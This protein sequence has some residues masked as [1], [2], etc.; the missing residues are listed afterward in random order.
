MEIVLVWPLSRGWRWRSVLQQIH[1]C[2]TRHT[3][4]VVQVIRG[5]NNDCSAV[6]CGDSNQQ[7]R[8]WCVNTCSP[9]R[10][11]R[12]C[13]PCFN[14]SNSFIH[15][16][17]TPASA[18]AVNPFADSKRESTQRAPHDLI[19]QTIRLPSFFQTDHKESLSSA[20]EQWCKRQIHKLTPP[21]CLVVGVLCVWVRE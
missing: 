7:L 8:S 17:S 6:H 1:A 3:T 16:S 9:L 13:V 18:R 4:L 20:P 14:T 21:L 15:K 19:P 10:S 12:N 11:N 2:S 5:F